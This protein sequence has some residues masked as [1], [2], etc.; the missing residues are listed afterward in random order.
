MPP[1]KSN[2]PAITKTASRF[3]RTKVFFAVALWDKIEAAYK[4]KETITGKV[5]DRIKGGLV[6]DIGVRAFLPGS[7]VDLRPVQNLDD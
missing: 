6:V 1:S 5:V 4:A 2:A 7:Q 3:S